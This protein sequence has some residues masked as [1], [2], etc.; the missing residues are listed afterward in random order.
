MPA[1]ALLRETLALR[2]F[3]LAKIP[4]LHWLRPVVVGLDDDRCVI[5][6][7]LG[8]RSRNHLG[9]MYFGALCAGADMAGGYAAMRHIQRSGR[10]V[11]FVFKDFRA[12]FRRRAE[13]DVHFVCDQGRAMAALV[14]RAIATGDR[15]EDSVRVVAV[16]PDGA[17]DDPVA[18]FLL[19]ISLR[20]RG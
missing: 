17:A 14:E 20:A 7:P 10:K 19:T 9:S 18:E 1:P 2:A 12:D 16:V 13:G 6:I 4:L 5:R 11:A 8:R 15:V 3:T